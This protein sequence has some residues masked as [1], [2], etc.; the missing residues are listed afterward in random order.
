MPFHFAP[1]C[2]RRAATRQNFLAK[3]SSTFVVRPR[4]SWPQSA[5]NGE[6]NQTRAAQNR[7]SCVPGTPVSTDMPQQLTTRPPSINCGSVAPQPLLAEEGQHAV[8]AVPIEKRGERRLTKFCP[9]RPAPPSPSGR[10]AVIRIG[11]TNTRPDSRCSVRSHCLSAAEAWTCEW[12]PGYPPPKAD[13]KF[14]SH[15]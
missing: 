14:K 12:T 8:A 15:P 10:M 1:R 9:V 11:G 5:K 6:T 3:L 2:G 7:C 4:A 13:F